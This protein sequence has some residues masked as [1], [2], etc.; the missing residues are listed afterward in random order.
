ML[1]SSF[2]LLVVLMLVVG[3][4]PRRE[5]GPLESEAGSAVFWSRNE[6]LLTWAED[7]SNNDQLRDAFI[8]NSGDDFLFG[9]LNS[10]DGDTAQILVNCTGDDRDSCDPESDTQIEWEGNGFT[11]I[12]ELEVP[13]TNGVD[14]TSHV[15][16]TA[17]FED[18]GE[19]ATLT[20]EVFITLEGN[21]DDC[22]SVN[23]QHRAISTNGQDMDRCTGTL[24]EDL[25]FEGVD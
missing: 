18:E 25:R 7:C 9:Y 13:L 1:R 15:T 21:V 8:V 12:T 10:D 6:S 3:C 2:F 20:T 16:R 5:P 4:F 19:R 11:E 24:D 23:E 22:A 14:C 17:V